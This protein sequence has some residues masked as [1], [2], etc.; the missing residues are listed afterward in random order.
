MAVIGQMKRRVEIQ[1]KSV[2]R[3][4]FGTETVSWRKVAAVWARVIQTGVSEDFQNDADREIAL[5]N[6]R[7]RIRFRTDVDETMRVVYDDLPWDIEGISEWGFKDQLELTVKTDVHNQPV[8]FTPLD[9]TLLRRITWGDDTL[10]TWGDG[11]IVNW[12]GI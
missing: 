2:S 9:P 4:D 6:A 10:V 3:D 7:I 8:T 11:T 1:R 5:R 12:R